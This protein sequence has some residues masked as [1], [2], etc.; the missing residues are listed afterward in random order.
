[1]SSEGCFDLLLVWYKFRGRESPSIL[2]GKTEG[3][4][5]GTTEEAPLLLRLT[6]FSGSAVVI[7]LGPFLVL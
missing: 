5:T 2:S 3:E 6:F 1:M 4:D 7:A